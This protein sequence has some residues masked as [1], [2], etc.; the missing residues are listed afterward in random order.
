MIKIGII[1]VRYFFKKKTY[2]P[3]TITIPKKSAF[4]QTAG[5]CR[6]YSMMN[7]LYLNTG[8]KIDESWIKDHIR[9]YWISTETAN[10]TK[11]SWALICDFLKDKNLRCYEIDVLT[12]PKLF[13]KLLLAW[14][15]FT[16]TRDCH[17]NVLQDIRD[18]NE[19]DDIII[20]KWA[21][22]AVNICFVNKKLMEY[23]SRWDYNIYNNFVYKTTDI[24]IKS[25]QAGAITSKV[26]FL[27]FSQTNGNK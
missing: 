2:N 10:D 11:Y 25:I 24:F 20:T 7:N 15:S 12:H 3:R 19:I 5:N 8:I 13:A 22:H 18:D 21:W 6:L 16:Y 27:D 1:I 23:G 17:N 26:R 4:Q 14:Y 9:K